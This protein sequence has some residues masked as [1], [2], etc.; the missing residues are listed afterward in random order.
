M[1]DQRFTD[2]VYDILDED[3]SES[4][5]WTEFITAISKLAHGDPKQRAMFLFDV[6]DDDGGGSIDEDELHGYLVASMR[7]SEEEM[8]PYFR[9]AC[10]DFTRR[11]LDA[12]DP[13][14]TGEL[15]RG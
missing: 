1:E 14:N 5:E 7:L 4:I 2:R 3:G 11:V 13:Q 10:R 9:E 12:V 8:T 15:T 6:Y